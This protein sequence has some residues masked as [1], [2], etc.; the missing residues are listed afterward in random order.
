MKA[1]L[2]GLIKSLRSKMH[3][4]DAAAAKIDAMRAA[5]GK[6]PGV[7]HASAADAAQADANPAGGAGTP[8]KSGNNPCSPGEVAIA[9]ADGAV[10]CSVDPSTENQVAY[11]Y[12]I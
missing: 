3:V 9:G 1:R 12:P 6:P 8:A 7:T 11:N 2:Q 10:G 4:F 5:A